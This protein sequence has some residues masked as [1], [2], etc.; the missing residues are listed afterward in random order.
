LKVFETPFPKFRSKTAKHGVWCHLRETVAGKWRT[1]W[2]LLDT[3]LALLFYYLTNQLLTT[4]K[5]VSLKT[6]EL[7]GYGVKNSVTFSTVETVGELF[8]KFRQGEW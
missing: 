8:I 2:L 7:V 4:P 3:Q 5:N 1:L 6:V